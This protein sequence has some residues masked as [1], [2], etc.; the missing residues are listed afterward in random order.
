MPVIL[1]G[2]SLMI[3]LLIAGCIF[4]KPI[5]AFMQHRY[6]TLLMMARRFCCGAA[7]GGVWVWAGGDVPGA[8][9]VKEAG[10]TRGDDYGTRFTDF[11]S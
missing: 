4:A 2:L 5:T 6:P 8:A 11:C 10:R 7:A 9:S 3:G 1:L